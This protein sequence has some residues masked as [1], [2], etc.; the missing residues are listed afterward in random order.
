MA[1]A[2]KE[3]AATASRWHSVAAGPSVEHMLRVPLP[4]AR[5]AFAKVDSRSEPEHRLRQLV[6]CE[7]ALHFTGPSWL[8]LD[9][10]LR[11]AHDLPADVGE[12]C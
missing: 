11:F 8:E 5:E 1:P 6:T 2:E 12:L 7:V 4:R 9:G 3:D 10:V